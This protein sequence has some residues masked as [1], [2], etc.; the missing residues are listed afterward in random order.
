MIQKSLQ[1][2]AAKAAQDKT[3]RFRSLARM[4]TV[5]FL[6]WC[7]TFIRKKAAAGV[8]NISAKEYEVELQTNVEDIV[9]QLKGQRYKAKLVKRQY[10]PKDNGKLRPLG[11]PA[12]SDKLVQTGAKIILESIYEQDFLPCSYGYRPR[13][14]ATNAVEDIYREL[15]SGRYHYIVEADIKGF[16]DNID[17]EILISMLNQRIDDKSFIRLI[18]K[19]LKAGVLDTDGKIICPATGT[20]QGGIISPVLANIYLHYALDIWF[21]QIVKVN[22]VGKAYLCRYADDFVCAFS[23]KYDAERFYNEL[24][25]RLA[26]FNL[27]LAEAKTNML[28]FSKS[29]RKDKTHFEFLGFEFRWG[30]SRLG[31]TVLKRRTSNKKLRKAIANFTEWCKANC[32][33]RM[34][35]LFGEINAKFRGYYNY[36]GLVG[37]SKALGSF[38]YW[39][40]INLFK[41][42]NR[43]SQKKSYNWQAFN[44]LIRHFNLLKPRIIKRPTQLG[45]GF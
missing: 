23:N 20:P 31:A 15:Q 27:Q 30:K 37:N 39:A 42:L 40:K 29:H 12:I 18:R 16:F 6:L 32:Q 44:D 9:T 26:L 3:Y 35:I 7:W 17:H 25:K 45:M 5:S 28:R 34:S 14:G 22:C 38:F 36:Y 21:E 24:A 43:R 13:T 2:I 41:W 19:W 11:I 4:L 33:K 1:G 10:I 8:D